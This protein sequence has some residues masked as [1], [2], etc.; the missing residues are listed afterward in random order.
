MIGTSMYVTTITVP[1]TKYN[2]HIQERRLKRKIRAKGQ[3][4]SE[5]ERCPLL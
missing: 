3:R 2:Q 4:K 1:I 5:Q